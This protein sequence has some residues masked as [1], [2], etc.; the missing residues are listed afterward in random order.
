MSITIPTKVQENV[1]DRK[2]K[3]GKS[4]TLLEDGNEKYIKA[5]LGLRE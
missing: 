2:C 3:N 5:N 4:E 1:Q